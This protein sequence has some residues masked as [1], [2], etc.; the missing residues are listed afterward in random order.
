MQD[1]K[2]LVRK[3]IAI[4]G[5]CGT[6]KS[7]AVTVLKN[8]FNLNVFYFGGVILDE[9]K[10]RNL[11]ANA[12]NENIIKEEFRKKHGKDALA[13][14]AMNKIDE[15]DISIV[16][17]GLYSFT[18]YKILH[19][20]YCENLITIAIHADK[21]IRYKRLSQR[22]CRPLSKDEVDMRDY[23]EIEKIEKGGPI[24][25]A[26][27]HIINNGEMGIFKKQLLDVMHKIL[28]N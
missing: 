5:M 6:G 11:E 25:I 20:K 27:Y 16:L 4:V 21:Q 8:E 7:E 26:D 18:E 22:V 14:I 24:S 15:S 2:G 9:I 12:E 23:T 28:E 3:I 10:K 1:S 17:D 19:N 13:K